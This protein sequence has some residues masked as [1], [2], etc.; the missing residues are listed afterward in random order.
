MRCAMNGTKEN[1]LFQTQG[2]DS[3]VIWLKRGRLS[4]TGQSSW[5]HHPSGASWSCEES[6]GWMPSSPCEWELSLL[7]IRP[8]GCVRHAAASS[9]PHC[10]GMSRLCSS[11][12]SPSVLLHSGCCAARH[13]VQL[14][15]P[16]WFAFV[17]VTLTSTWA[18]LCSCLN[19]Q[20][21]KPVY[22]MGI[23]WWSS[24]SNAVF[25]MCFC[26]RIFDGELGPWA[27]HIV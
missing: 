22:G 5:H 20:S 6:Q 12:G 23:R 14:A 25:W 7:R 2:A 16:A 19:S 26:M 11:G 10:T 4:C 1:M 3:F 15:P 8:L 24:V 21:A 18:W 27:S 9:F 13:G 17:T